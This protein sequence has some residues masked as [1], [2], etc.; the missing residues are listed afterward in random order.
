MTETINYP[1]EDQRVVLYTSDGSKLTGSVNIVGRTLFE[2]LNDAD[3]DVIL[4]D[5]ICDEESIGTLLV[6]KKQILWIEAL[7]WK[8]EKPALGNWHKIRVKL[9][10]GS[11]FIGDVD[12]S[13]YDRTSDYL[14]VYNDYYYEFF[15]CMAEGK[16]F[17]SIFVSVSNSVWKE[18][19][20]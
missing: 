4:Y 19:L 5:A 13:G 9:S 1:K 10:A 2:Y 12:I 18:P 7:E 17:N 3:T 11:V 14:K 20:T 15:E 16:L 8:R 6:S